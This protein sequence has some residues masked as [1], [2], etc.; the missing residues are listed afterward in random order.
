[1]WTGVSVALLTSFYPLDLLGAD[2]TICPLPDE[3][4]VL[5]PVAEGAVTQTIWRWLEYGNGAA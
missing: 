5:G 1:M 3:K 2:T 4:D